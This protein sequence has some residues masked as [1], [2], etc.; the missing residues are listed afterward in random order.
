MPRSGKPRVTTPSED[1]YIWVLNLMNRTVTV[2]STVAE[3][4]GHRISRHTV[5]R[6]LRQYGIHHYRVP[7]LTPRHRN[8][9]L[10]WARQVRRWKPRDW[11][12]AM[13]S[14]ESRFLIFINDGRQ[15]VNRR[16]GE[17]LTPN[18]IQ[19]CPAVW[20]WRVNGLGWHMW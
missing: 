4:L 6:R 14:E 16:F 7:L 1:R 5:Y 9:K 12:R 11:A 15:L 13:F 2:T 17:R 19:L 3:T 18:C 8:N 20:R 10:R